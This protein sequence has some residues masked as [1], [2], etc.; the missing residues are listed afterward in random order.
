MIDASW[1]DCLLI[2]YSHHTSP[3][4]GSLQKGTA[5]NRLL[6]RFQVKGTCRVEINDET[7]VVQPGDLIIRKPGGILPVSG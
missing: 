4:T 5:D 7:H 3:F 6:L 2:G 1:I